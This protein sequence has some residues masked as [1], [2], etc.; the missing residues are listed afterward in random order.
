M[1]MVM[2][3]SRRAPDLPPHAA[4]PAAATAAS[5]NIVRL[6]IHDLR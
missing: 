5:Q 2:R 3:S 1:A 4:V 6:L